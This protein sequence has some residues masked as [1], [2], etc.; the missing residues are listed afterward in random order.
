MWSLSLVTA[1]A[2]GA[3]LA[4]TIHASSI[5]RDLRSLRN[6]AAAAE[7]DGGNIV[8]R[9]QEHKH[10]L[11]LPGFPL[12]DPTESYWQDP[13]H[14]I[15]N[16]R[17]T[18]KLPSHETFDYVIIG[19]GI[20]G[21]ATAHKL[22][23]RDPSLSILMLEARTA[24][25][26]ATGRNGGHARPGAWKSVKKWVDAYGEDEG[27]RIGRMEQDCVDDVADF[28][29][30][31]NAS[32]DFTEVESADVYWTREGL[33][34]ALDVVDFQRELEDRR[35]AD[36]P[37]NNRTVYLGQEARDY[38]RWPE[39]IGAVTFTA[40]TQN[41][42]R[43]VCAMIE[44]SLNRGLNL[45]TN[46]MALRLE[47]VTDKAEDAGA[48]AEAEAEADAAG[49]RWRVKTNRGTVKGR[50]VVLAT[51]GFT[52]ALHPGFAATKFLTPSRSQVTAVQ[53]EKE[54]SGN[55]VFTR[56][57]SYP[58]LH[59]GNNYIAACPPGSSCEGTLVVGG[60]TQLSPTK[61]LNTSDDTVVNEQI[62][63]A[64]H[65]VGRVAYGYQN[66]GLSTTVLGDW[67]GITCETPD[68]F[69]VVGEVPEE[70]GLW[71]IVCHNGHGMAWAYRSA[72]A[73]VEMMTNDD[74]KAPEWFP[75]PFNAQRAWDYN[76]EKE[77][78]NEG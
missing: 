69:P 26:G 55:V 15:A 30:A 74:G 42:Y 31:H 45:Q 43:T 75:K 24:A 60:S 29:R 71:A 36:L 47:K 21:A 34:A 48:K 20:S 67:T 13:P 2:I 77:E 40:Y 39:I 1:L 46:T 22:L 18:P 28:A 57:N 19:S 50:K 35:P 12:P 33:D 61:E 58:D 54:T 38:W 37:R 14:R 59:S 8:E 9:E 32:S 41:P 17:T 78:S 68:G 72:E 76:P 3:S 66:W 64:L 16:L 53:P 7:D 56:S 10:K 51:N 4:P 49:A 5:E 6:A 23:S 44:Q 63:S 11:R 62:A 65:G 25:S 52:S 73:L 70:D 27:L